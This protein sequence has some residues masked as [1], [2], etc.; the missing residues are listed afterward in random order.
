MTRVAVYGAN[1]FTGKL[2]VAELA[3]RE[4]DT[5]LVG[6]DPERLRASAKPAAEVRV[7]DLSDPARLADAFRDC[8]V[9]VNGVA[10]YVSYGMPVVRA[11][12][13]AGCH[14]VDFAGEQPFINEVFD[15]LGEEAARAGVT[16]VPMVNDGGFAADL[17]AS[18]VAGRLE[19]V[20]S[21]T[22]THRFTGTAALSRGSVRSA[23][24]NL[25]VL[26][27]SGPGALPELATL[28]RH[29]QARH[30]RAEL[31]EAVAELFTSMTAELVESIPADGP[32]EA[33]RQASG[34]VL[35]AEASDVNDARRVRGVVEGTDTYGTTAF[36]AVEAV[37][38][39]AN[40]GAKPG[41]LAPAQAFDPVDFLD[42]LAVQGVRWS[43]GL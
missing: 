11:A 9:V 42:S 39:L 32:N 14:Y 17:I 22:I 34:Y 28:H 38:R 10:P 29:I 3:R 13:A 23:L 43:V 41:V 16:V 33:D 21:L 12:I 4:V 18:I 35:T 15:S 25:E 5:V 19:N 1:G 6:R 2:A 31:E 36:T 30:I 24:A 37:L 26:R 8:A 7:A 40:D 20:D 27:S